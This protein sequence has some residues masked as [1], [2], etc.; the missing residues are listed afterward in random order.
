MSIQ[1]RPKKG[2]PLP[3]GWKKPKW[4][5]RYR[6]PSGKEHS[7]T[8]T[9]EKAAKDFDKD[10]GVK[11]AR[12]TWIDPADEKTTL[13]QLVD[14]WVAQARNDGTRGVREG[15][16]ANLGDL[17]DMPVGQI[18]SSHIK[19]WATDL[20]RGRPWKGGRP[21]AD[22]TT[23]QHISRMKGIFDRAVEDGLISRSPVPSTL[24][25]SILQDREVQE[26]EVPT[27]DQVKAMCRAAE[28]GGE[29][30]N[31]RVKKVAGR[32]KLR[33]A[34]WLAMAIRLGVDTG[35]RVGELSGLQ[36]RDVDLEGRR[37]HVERQC[38][39]K[40]QVYSGLKTK[41]SRRVVPLSRAM[42]REL[43]QWRVGRG[44]EDPVVPGIGGRGTSSIQLSQ[45]MRVLGAVVGLDDRL[46]RFHGLR[47]LYAS[48]MLQSGEPITTV[49]ALIGDSVPTTSR[50][51]AHWLRGAQD[52]ARASVESLAGS[53]RDGSPVLRVVD[54]GRG[55]SVG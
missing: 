41:R 35:L 32:S 40:L 12:G 39:K 53:V 42:A 31:G 47:H 2:D 28:A 51:Y 25:S 21:L 36:W 44:P 20:Y 5:V 17:A 16:R 55:R 13:A 7:K 1:R 34:P 3:D 33:P 11:L 8:F 9:T 19:K 4:V 18:R 14:E 30:A 38:I 50:V 23:G 54:G 43:E 26:R 27:F 24:K 15:F 52:A 37:I 29:F 46:W 22:T 6:D 45:V 49:A 48:S 10:Q